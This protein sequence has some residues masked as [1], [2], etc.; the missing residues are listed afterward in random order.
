VKARSVFLVYAGL[1]ALVTLGR[2]G[3]A[4]LT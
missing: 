3:L 2:A 4:A 1:W